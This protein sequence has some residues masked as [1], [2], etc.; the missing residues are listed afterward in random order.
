MRDLIL[1]RPPKDYDVI[2][3]ANLKQVLYLIVLLVLPCSIHYVLVIA[4]LISFFFGY[5]S[6]GC[7]IVLRL[8][9]DGFLFVTCG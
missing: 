4:S 5:R 3:T 9:G 8:L 6:G 2:T 7:F 1:H